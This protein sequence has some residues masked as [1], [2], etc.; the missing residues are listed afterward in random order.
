MMML[1]QLR[2]GRQDN[3]TWVMMMMMILHQVR[4]GRQ[5]NHLGGTSHGM[6]YEALTCIEVCIEA[7]PQYGFAA[8]HI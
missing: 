3:H 7:T 8:G 4:H 1:H 2:H 5:D 6:D